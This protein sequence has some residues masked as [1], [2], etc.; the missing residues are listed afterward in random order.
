MN[1]GGDGIVKALVGVRSEIN[2]ERRLGR[3]GAGDFDVQQDLAI[4]A[5]GITGGFIVAAVHGDGHDF[6]GLHV[7]SGLEVALN[8]ARL[9]STT[10]FDDSDALAGA[11]GIRREIIELGN[12]H[13]GE[14]AGRLCRQGMSGYGRTMRAK[15][16]PRCRTVVEAQD[17]GDDAVQFRGH[18]EESGAAAIR[19]AGRLVIQQ[20][21]V[22]R[23]AEV[24]TV[25]DSVTEPFAWCVSEILSPYS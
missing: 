18:V 19:S 1:G 17:G 16:G 24:A 25:P 10:Q 20:L 8:V 6:G 12:L 21:D 4:G 14:G 13:R 23:F 15:V 7:Q 5:T 11:I 2:G 9:E 22:K 3:D